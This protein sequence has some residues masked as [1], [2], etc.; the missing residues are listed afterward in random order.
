MSFF[1][2]L[3]VIRHLVQSTNYI[4]INLSGFPSPV[5]FINISI[6]GFKRFK[7]LVI[8]GYLGYSCLLEFISFYTSFN[9]LS[10][11]IGLTDFG[12]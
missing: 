4:Y 2:G 3:V 6:T 10:C 12:Y 8:F 5:L 9:V 7:L 11:M 1:G